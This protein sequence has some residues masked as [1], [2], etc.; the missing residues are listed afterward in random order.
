MPDKSLVGID[1][2]EERAADSSRAHGRRGHAPSPRCPSRCNVIN[3]DDIIEEFG[4][5]TFRLYE[6]Y[7]GPRG[8]QAGTPTTRSG[9]SGSSNT[10]RLCV[11]E[12]PAARFRRDRR[13]RRREQLHR[14]IAKVGEDVERLAFNTAIASMIEFVNA[15]LKTGVTRDQMDR[16]V[17]ML[18]R[19]RALC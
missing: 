2:V 15:A 8:E 5:D 18:A 6:M 3:P 7:M 12:T 9:S 1:C 4:A 17:R 10:R 11:D 13:R 19:L 14:T 16:F